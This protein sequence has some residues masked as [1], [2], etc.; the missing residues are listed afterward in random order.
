MGADIREAMQY[1][2]MRPPIAS[3]QDS[4]GGGIPLPKA[5]VSLVKGVPIRELA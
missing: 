4:Q 5:T 2:A 1:Q 3:T